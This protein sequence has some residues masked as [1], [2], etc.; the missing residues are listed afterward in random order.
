MISIK[1]IHVLEWDGSSESGDQWKIGVKRFPISHNFVSALE[2]SVSNPKIFDQIRALYSVF[3]MKLLIFII[4]SR[5]SYCIGDVSFRPEPVVESVGSW[6]DNR[7]LHNDLYSLFRSLWH[8]FR[9]FMISVI[10]S[11]KFFFQCNR[12]LVHTGLVYLETPFYYC[13]N[14]TVSTIPG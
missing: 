12:C 2:N 3:V 8:C 1:F 5:R 9:N 10:F 4:S 7:H 14:Y 13:Y 11:T 6:F